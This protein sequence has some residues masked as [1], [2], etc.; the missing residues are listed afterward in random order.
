MGLFLLHVRRAQ[1][2]QIRFAGSL[3]RLQRLQLRAQR[4]VFFMFPR[5]RGQRAVYGGKFPFG[6]GDEAGFIVPD[7]V[8]PCKQPLVG[9]SKADSLV[10]GRDECGQTRFQIGVCCQSESRLADSLDSRLS[11]GVS[12]S[13]AC[14]TKALRWYT[15]FGTPRS[16]S[17][18]FAP[19]MPS[20]GSPESV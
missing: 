13:P 9:G 10:A 16:I 3:L 8:L 18:Q 19:V 7:T 2:P 20:T 4:Q 6:V 1:R 17:P 14:R 11:S 5:Q 15:L 12:P